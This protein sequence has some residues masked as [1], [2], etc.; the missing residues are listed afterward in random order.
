MTTT[1]DNAIHKCQ[2]CR[3]K[4][5]QAGLGFLVRGFNII[6]YLFRKVRDLL[7]SL[8]YDSKPLSFLLMKLFQSLLDHVYN[9][10]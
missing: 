6:N 3:S 5:Q 10:F 8:G 1:L 2:K 9:M 4:V 7:I